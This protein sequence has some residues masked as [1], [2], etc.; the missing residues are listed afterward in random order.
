M[1]LK[2]VLSLKSNF[3]AIFRF[4]FFKFEWPCSTFRAKSQL[5]EI[6][7]QIKL[8][9]AHFAAHGIFGENTALE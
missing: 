8:L 7:F 6:H 1:L 2:L 5:A 4:K 9:G 3:S